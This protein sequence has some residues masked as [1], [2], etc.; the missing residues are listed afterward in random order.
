MKKLS[1]FGTP[2]SQTV[3]LEQFNDPVAMSCGWSEL[4]AN[5]ANFTTHMIFKKNDGSLIYKPTIK[6]KI[7]GSA[8][9]MMGIGLL[10]T[11]FISLVPRLIILVIGLVFLI[12]GLI[13]IIQNMTPLGFDSKKRI[14][15]RGNKS[16]K[17]SKNINSEN[18]QPFTDIHAIQLITKVGEISD[19]ES[20]AK[21][22]YIYELNLVLNN[23]NRIYVMAYV[24]PQQALS[25]AKLI[26][27]LLDIPIWNS[28]T[29][30]NTLD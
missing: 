26:S 30:Y 21:Y 1:S 25:D 13:I 2:K 8:F 4:K 12:V 11:Y 29:G 5:P 18:A 10:Y 6:V 9:I 24:N 17:S 28:I 3:D 19:N 22:F 27:K 16:K 23:S 20:Q 7:F 14:Y 15:Y